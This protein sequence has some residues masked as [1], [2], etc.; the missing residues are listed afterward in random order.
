MQNEPNGR[1]LANFQYAVYL[2][3]GQVPL[4]SLEPEHVGWLGQEDEASG[5]KERELLRIAG[6]GHN[7]LMLVGQAAYFEAIRRFCQHH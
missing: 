5:A 7:D 3:Y 1:S 6:A 2:A 4:F